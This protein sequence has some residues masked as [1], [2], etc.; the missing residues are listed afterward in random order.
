MIIASMTTIVADLL[1]YQLLYANDGLPLGLVAAIH[2]VGSPTYFLSPDFWACL[3]TTGRVLRTIFISALVLLCAILA[4]F[5]GP[6]AAT[7]LL[8]NLSS[9][10]LAGG[11]GFSLTGPEGAAGDYHWPNSLGM[12]ATGHPVTCSEFYSR[13]LLPGVYNL[14]SF[15][16]AAWDGNVGRNYCNWAGYL[17]LHAAFT[18]WHLN[19]KQS[20]IPMQDGISNREIALKP[21][22]SATSEG[23]TAV[24]VRLVDALYSDVL[25][26]AWTEALYNAPSTSKPLSR[27]AWKFRQLNGTS[28]SVRSWL[29]A[30]RTDCRVYDLSLADANTSYAFGKW[31][32]ED[33]HNP[34]ISISENLTSMT[35]TWWDPR[36]LNFTLSS[37]P[38]S[39][40]LSLQYPTIDQNNSTWGPWLVNCAIDA[41]W[42]RGDVVGTGLEQA[43]DVLRYRPQPLDTEL[44]PSEATL[45]SIKVMA[46]FGWLYTLNSVTKL[47]TE[48]QVSAFT[49]LLSSLDN[50]NST[51]SIIGT[52]NWRTSLEM[53]ISAYYAD[54]MSR[55]GL[56]DNSLNLLGDREEFLAAYTAPHDPASL[57]LLLESKYILPPYNSTLPQTPMSWQITITGLSY[58]IRGSSSIFSITILLTYVLLALLHTLYCGY[59][60]Q[61]STTYEKLTEL[62][63]LLLT[64]PQPNDVLQN[65]CAGIDSLKTYQLIAKVR[66]IDSGSPSA[67]PAPTAS[68]SSSRQEQVQMVLRMAQKRSSEPAGYQQVK[69]GL[70]YGVTP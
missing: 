32:I 43:R 26:N 52:L 1:T 60:R 39:S 57:D 13:F 9:D 14:S 27:A 49:Y 48:A 53:A 18:D 50:V 11:A 44:F 16:G 17:N 5:S 45:T 12:S 30:V 38:V 70:A 3:G 68:G 62:F 58:R 21:R 2:S 59:T 41:R 40:L 6:V 65:T 47:S 7:L 63:V 31:A 35:P 66:A 69:L 46:Q 29:P 51:A 61:N 28:A 24:A 15:L 42:A 33:L 19:T 54:A 36:T 20:A 64:S 67:P 8:P 23:S 22:T 34:D 10:W 37:A 56:F 25:A 4:L 55:N